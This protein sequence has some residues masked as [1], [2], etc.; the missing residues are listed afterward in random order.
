YPVIG[1]PVW[2]QWFTYINP[3]AYAIHAMRS[4]M[5]RGQGIGVI[6]TDLAALGIFTVV[7]LCIGI[8]TYRRT[9]E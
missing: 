8:L 4:I 7:T 3:N 2:L 9:I 6:G 5:L 1:M